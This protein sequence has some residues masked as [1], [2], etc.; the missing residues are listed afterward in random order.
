MGF[1]SEVTQWLLLGNKK[2]N[3]GTYASSDSA[4]GGELDTQLKIVDFVIL[5]P[6]GS[7]AT[8]QPVINA[9]FPSTNPVAIVTA[10]DEAGFFIAVGQG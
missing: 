3:I 5:I 1:I 8:S 2:L 9:T 10:Q 4:T 6:Y 7:S